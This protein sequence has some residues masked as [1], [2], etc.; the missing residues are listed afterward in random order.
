MGPKQTSH[1][2]GGIEM[3]RVARLLS[4]DARMAVITHAIRRSR[5]AVLHSAARGNIRRD[6]RSVEKR[7]ERGIWVAMSFETENV[8]QKMETNLLSPFGSDNLE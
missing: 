5:S 8:H 7:V 6:R 2:V 3:S 1:H 4:A